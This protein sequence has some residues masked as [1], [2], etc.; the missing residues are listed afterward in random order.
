MRT[1]RAFL[2]H[3]LAT[4]P[5]SPTPKQAGW[6]DWLNPSKQTTQT[7]RVEP[8]VA[9]PSNGAAPSAPSADSPKK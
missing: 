1:F 7:T 2:K 6:F 4:Q 8:N 5:N 3:L 9:A